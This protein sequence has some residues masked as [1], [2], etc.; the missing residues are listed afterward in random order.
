MEDHLAFGFELAR[1]LGGE[2]GEVVAVELYGR[3]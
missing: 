1:A 3:F 2:G